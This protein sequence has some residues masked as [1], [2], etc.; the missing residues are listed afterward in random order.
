MVPDKNSIKSKSSD[1][2]ECQNF[3]MQNESGGQTKG[4]TGFSKRLSDRNKWPRSWWWPVI[5]AEGADSQIDYK[6]NHDELS[7]TIRR[8]MLTIVAYGAFCLFTLSAPD[9]ELLKN[10]IKVPFANIELDFMNFLF[11]GPLILVGLVIYLQIFI[12]YWHQIP[13]D[14]IGQPLPFIFNLPGKVPRL[15]SL[16]LFYW[17]PPG[18]LFVFVFKAQPHTDATLLSLGAVFFTAILIFLQIRRWNELEYARRKFSYRL[19]WACM[20]LLL[21]IVLSLVAPLSINLFI[22]SI[23][24][25]QLPTAMRG[26]DLPNE[27]LR[28]I[29]LV[30]R[31]LRR[32]NLRGANL[33]GTDLSKRD[34]TQAD[35]R[36]ANL[37]NSNLTET[38]L[39]E[40]DLGDANLKNANLTKALIKY[41]HFG[42]ADL[43]GADFNNAVFNDPLLRDSDLRGAKNLTCAQLQ[44]ATNWETAYRDPELSCGAPIPKK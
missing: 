19:L 42:R 28:N 5:T 10:K 25:K 38:N 29:S 44:E 6:K 30:G 27:D 21:V 1:N 14:K 26:L 12:G 32:A 20:S 43:R 15:L 17:L 4:I 13:R 8:V 33:Y 3:A 35:L 41:V 23:E 11:V 36:G 37:E 7:V 22:T 2:T 31:D 34:L 18:V 40:V 9:T 16:F 24:K 39:S